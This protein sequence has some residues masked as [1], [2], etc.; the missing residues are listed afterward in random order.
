[1]L[2]ISI[3]KRFEFIIEPTDIEN[4]EDSVLD[5]L[6]FGYIFIVILAYLLYLIAPYLRIISETPLYSFQ[7]YFAAIGIILLIWDLFTER[8]C[9]KSRYVIF[10]Y[11]LCLICFF[12]MLKMGKYGYKDNLFDLVWFSIQFGIFY[13]YTT[14]AKHNKIKKLFKYLYLVVGIIWSI[15]C[16]L[17]I[18]QFA[19][20]VGYRMIADIHTDNPELVRQGLW[21]NRLFGIFRGIDYSAY[22]SLLMIIGSIYY[23]RKSHTLTLKLINIFFIIPCFIYIILSYSRS[24]ILS[25][26]IST[27][28]L[29]AY[30]CISFF[31][32]KTVKYHNF[33]TII[34]IFM[35]SL[36]M[37]S[38]IQGIQ[39]LAEYSLNKRI[40]ENNYQVFDSQVVDK[41]NTILILT[42]KG[43]NQNNQQKIILD[44]EELEENIFDS[45]GRFAIWHDY[46]YLMGD[47]GLLGLS[48]SNYNNYIY[49]HHKDLYITRYFQDLRDKSGKEDLVYESHNNYLFILAS[50]GYLGFLCFFLFMLNIVIFNIKT[51][52]RI[53][54][55]KG[56]SDFSYII[57]LLIIIVISTGALFM[58]NAFLK[59]NIISFIFWLS[60]GF[61]INKA[62]LM[63]NQITQL[64]KNNHSI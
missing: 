56:P 43:Y 61:V 18:I 8:K 52:Y 63:N 58:N 44:R 50:T 33:Y 51:L 9:L 46:L 53:F 38:M 22:I 16:I 10:L 32:K 4:K 49:D 13:S 47:Y 2:N 39:K 34:I 19:N 45:N 7:R 60:L 54:K 27:I 31:R 29:S 20:G 64:S 30:F 21:S 3:P 37:L 40:E 59:I 62:T 12:S 26:I 14:T 1:M 48:T 36:I 28:I 41:E 6:T 42:N 55:R 25:L 23:V 35:S 17:S 11:I 57:M 5:K 24:A 15:S